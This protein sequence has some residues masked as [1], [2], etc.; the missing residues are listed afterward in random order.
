MLPAFA[1]T[2]KNISVRRQLRRCRRLLSSLPDA[3]LSFQE[4]ER[5]SFKRDG[6][7]ACEGVIR[8]EIAKVL[9]EHFDELFAGN[10]PT[11]VYPDEW[12]WRQG[13]SRPEAFREIVNAWKSSPL[14]ASVALSPTLGRLAAELMGWT[15]G[16]RIGQEDVL[17][18]PP[19][20]AGV[21]YH[22]DSA[23]I[24]SNFRPVD[25][26]SV[27]VWIALDDADEE[28]GVVEYAVGSHRW[29]PVID[30]SAVDSSF[31]GSED[32]L[33]SV[34]SVAS[35][36]GAELEIR[37]LVVPCGGAVFHHQDVWHG[38]G[39]NVSLHRPRRALGVH[40][41]RSDL[42]FRNSPPPD[43]IYGR[44]TLGEGETEVSEQ[45][46]PIVWSPSGYVSPIVQRLLSETQTFPGVA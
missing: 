41:L 9:R 22:Q 7:L 1:A 46:F 6:F 4:T 26:N 3:R 38:S 16:A 37:R 15:V 5:L 27:T 11:G 32:V 13:I 42:R 18:K 28:T 39:R 21:G 14:V 33:A 8:P 23:Y 12:H 34:R 44:Y 36:V 29:P 43:Y 31:H 30:K 24:S 2:S 35:A 17:W 25:N 40:L 20:A 45:F 19:G 10:F